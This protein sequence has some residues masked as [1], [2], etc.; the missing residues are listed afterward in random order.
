MVDPMPRVLRVALIA[1]RAAQGGSL[2][3]V[4]E[5]GGLQVAM[6]QTIC[7]YDPEGVSSDDIDVL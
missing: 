5:A 6:N 3:D 7:D 4:L 1:E 2:K